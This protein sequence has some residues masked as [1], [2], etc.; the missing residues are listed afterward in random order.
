MI[1][2]QCEDADCKIVRNPLTVN[3]NNFISDLRFRVLAESSNLTNS[4]DELDSLFNPS[5]QIINYSEKS[6]RNTA[7]EVL[8]KSNANS[9]TLEIRKFSKSD[10][11][12]YQCQLNS[13]QV[14]TIHYCVSLHSKI[15]ILIF[16]L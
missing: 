4:E 5:R 6:L 1:W 2:N 12:C 11:A 16:N 7:Q 10:E 14:K 13:F 15:L 3:R 9:W 8:A